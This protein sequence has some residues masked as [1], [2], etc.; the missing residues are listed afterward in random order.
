M[1]GITFVTKTKTP[2]L[3]ELTFK[4][5]PL[6]AFRLGT[7]LKVSANPFVDSINMFND[8]TVGVMCEGV[9]L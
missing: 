3:M 5:Q 9:V 6:P 1:L 8:R 2:A 4:Q 7:I